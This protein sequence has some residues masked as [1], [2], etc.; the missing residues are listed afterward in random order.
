MPLSGPGAYVEL[1]VVL[2]TLVAMWIGLASYY[3]GR[4]VGAYLALA[5]R[6]ILDAQIMRADA[7]RQWTIGQLPTMLLPTVPVRVRPAPRSR[8]LNGT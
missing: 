1:G 7:E 3:V 4:Q 6:T 5:D 2:G 8:R